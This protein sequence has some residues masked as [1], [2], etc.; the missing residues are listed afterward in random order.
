MMRAE[1]GIKVAQNSDADGVAHGSDC[2][3]GNAKDLPGKCLLQ[4]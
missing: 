4:G 3:R 1:I 2:T